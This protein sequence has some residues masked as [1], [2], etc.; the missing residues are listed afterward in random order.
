LEKNTAL[1]KVPVAITDATYDTMDSSVRTLMEIL[2]LHPWLQGLRGKMVFIKP[3]LLGVFP[4]ERH[5]T[6][7][8]EL[9]KSMVSLVRDY[10]ARVTV[11]DNCG[12]G[13][14]GLNQRVAKHTGILEAA[15]GAYQNVAQKTTVVKL[16]SRHVNSV[17]V[18]RDMLEADVLINLPVM[19]T[20]SLTIVT[21][22][23]KNMFGIVAG[24]GKGNLHAAAPSTE[25]FGRMLAEIFAIRPP[26]LTVMDAVTAMEGYGP[27]AGKPIW[28]GKILASKNAVALDA[29]VCRIMGI[30]PDQV[31]HVREAS[32]LGHG[33]I[34]SA[35]IEII[36]NLPRNPKFKLPMEASRLKFIQSISGYFFGRLVR[37]KL[38]L[39]KKKCRKCKLCVEGC[40]TGAMN[41]NDLPWI[42]EQK[43][44]RCLCCCELCPESAW[45]MRG[46][47]RR[48]QGHGV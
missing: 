8:P 42:D 47:M 11:G 9:V 34:D 12:V 4:A 15:Q 37:N 21:G 43:C 25:S 22:G 39:S 1:Q 29:V 19:K 24:G 44:I 23:I 28:V 18:S 2:G 17:V 10:G 16:N 32:S 7:S 30:G 35:S 41:M 5:V 6:T 27:S 48:L 38:K 13:G 31:H 46:M 26:D 45:E 14:Y 33:P 36:G 40:P 3:N 20:H